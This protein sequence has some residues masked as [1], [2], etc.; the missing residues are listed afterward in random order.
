MWL[1]IAMFLA[2]RMHL[3]MFLCKQ[4]SGLMENAVCKKLCRVKEGSNRM[5]LLGKTLESP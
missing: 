4:I 2:I 3:N 5:L 1:M